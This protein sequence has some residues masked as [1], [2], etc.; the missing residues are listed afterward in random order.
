[1]QKASHGTKDPQSVMSKNIWTTLR[2]AV[3]LMGRPDLYSACDANDL[4]KLNSEFIHS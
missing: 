1:M 2:M 4:D 3:S